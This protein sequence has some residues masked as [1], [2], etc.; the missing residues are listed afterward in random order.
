MW[1]AWTLEACGHRSLQ[2]PPAAGSSVV[3]PGCLVRV[4][5]PDRTLRVL[6]RVLRLGQGPG[7]GH[8]SPGSLGAMEGSR[9]APQPYL[10][11]V[12]EKLRRVSPGAIRVT[13]P[14]G[15]GSRPGKEAADFGFGV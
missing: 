15:R 12:L 1:T 4:W 9:A 3:C 6:C 13:W 10:G 11:L 5:V 7:W 2:Q 14:R 8:Y